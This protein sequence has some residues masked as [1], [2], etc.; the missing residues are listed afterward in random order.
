MWEVGSRLDATGRARR[1]VYAVLA[2][3]IEASVA[4]FVC[5]GLI[6]SIGGELVCV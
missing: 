5:G 6:P 2:L 1:L 4:E 3:L